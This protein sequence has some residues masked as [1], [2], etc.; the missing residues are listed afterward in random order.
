MI[1]SSKKNWSL[2]SSF[3]FVEKVLKKNKCRKQ[4]LGKTRFWATNFHI[5]REVFRD[6]KFDLMHDTNSE[7]QLKLPL[8]Q[9]DTHIHIQK[10]NAAA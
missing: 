6:P 8:W 3:E 10:N 2:K 1:K 9:K 4:V 7:A 5:C